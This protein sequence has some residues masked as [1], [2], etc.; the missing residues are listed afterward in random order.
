[1]DSSSSARRC[2]P[3]LL[4]LV[5]SEGARHFAERIALALG[6]RI[7]FLTTREDALRRAREGALLM[8]E[9]GQT[10]PGWALSLVRRLHRANPDLLIAVMPRT[11]DED[12][13]DLLEAGASVVIAE[14]QAPAQAA[15]SIRAAE[16][17]MA[18][19]DPNV[20]G[21]I[22][23][24]VQCLSQLCVDQNVEVARCGA[25]TRRERE[26]AGLLAM[27]AT[28]EQ[29]SERLGIAVGTVKT[30]VHNIL[31]KLEVDGRSLAGV[32][33]RLYTEDGAGR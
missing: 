24:R 29:I 30:H 19:L 21:A 13:A 16:A 26:V 18:I 10:P 15:E 17:G 25:L 4:A 22:I 27:R 7:Q 9:G 5:T 2:G 23:R 6:C 11:P 8:L 20:V 28:N 1:M 33:W 3:V 31:E 32:Y 14:D 12:V